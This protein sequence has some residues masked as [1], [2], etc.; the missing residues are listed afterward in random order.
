MD[1][2]NEAEPSISDIVQM[3]PWKHALLATYTLSLSYFESEILR[4]LLRGGC[5]DIWL[6]A[7]AEGYRSSLLERRSMRVGQE[8]RLIPVALPDG[9][10]HAKC[11]Y[12]AGDDGDLLLVGSGNL[13]FGG[14]GK[15]AEVFEALSPD[16]AAGA[17]RDFADFLEAVGSR[18]DIRIARSEW[19]EDFAGRARAAADQGVNQDGSPP[20]RLVHSVD[21]PVIDQLPGLLAPYGACSRAVVMS[22]YHDH[23]GLAVRTLAERLKLSSTDVAVTKAGASPFPFA[24]TVAWSHPVSP[25]RPSRED[26]RF[27]H[28]KWYE[29]QMVTHRLLLT[30]SINATRKALTTS[31]NVELGV[32]RALPSGSVPLA[33][34]VVGLPAFEPQ[35]RM[36]SGLKK[37]EIVYAGFDRHDASLLKGGII[38][39]QSTQ[40]VWTGR[41]VQADG[42]ATSFEVAVEPDGRFAVRSPALEAFSEMPALQIVMTMDEREARGWVHNEMFLSLSGRRRLSV[43]SLSRLMRREGTDDDFEALLDYLSVQAERHLRM[44]DRPVLKALDEGGDQN[45]AAKSVTVNLADL[46]PGAESS[47]GAT[48]PTGISFTPDQ[49]DVAMSRLR[50]ILLGHGRAKTAPL[51]HSG[52]SVVA[53]EDDPGAGGEEGP[54]QDEHASKLGLADFEREI[55]RL[56]KDADDKPDVLRGLLAMELEVVMWMRIHRLGDL[57]GAHEFLQSWFLKACRLAKP[58]PKRLT[59]LQQHIVTGAAILFRLASGAGKA[60]AEL[61]DSLERY[62]GGTVDREKALGSLIPDVDAGFAA[63]LSDVSDQAALADSLTTILAQRTTRQQLA[64]ALTLASEAQ[65]VP[66]DWEVFSSPLGAELNKA[67]SRPDWQKKVRRAGRSDSKACAFQ[68]FSFSPQ[69]A[70]EFQR[71]RF[72]KCI[73]CNRFTVNLHL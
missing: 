63:L 21:E 16:S 2:Q 49:F 22:P 12:L 67:L 51:Q 19:V 3:R 17:F 66:A 58:E 70:A 36:P 50:R 61:H 8:Y 40:G 13:T 54:A 7:D 15:N 1:D 20:L 55:G 43:G 69:Q 10:F 59:S 31:D 73:H 41:L 30:G 71:L 56:I 57:D 29:F 25:V 34:E 32:L 28:A 37:N 65:A 53:E 60:A 38:S 52:E 6:I 42:E 9:V 5:S 48:S 11:I 39:L 47:Q 18:P 26:K 68:Q 44:F 4:P 62:F 35:E 24:Q 23:D 45:G 72:A 46:A 14:H 27:V 33:W 64:D